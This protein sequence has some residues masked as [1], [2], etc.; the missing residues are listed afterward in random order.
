MMVGKSSEITDPTA[1]GRGSSPAKLCGE[2][3]STLQTRSSLHPI[4]AFTM[5]VSASENLGH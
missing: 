2:V 5:T 4:H 3:S 1:Q